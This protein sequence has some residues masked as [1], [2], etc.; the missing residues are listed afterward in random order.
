MQIINKEK[1]IIDHL[2]NILNEGQKY[3]QNGLLNR[4]SVKEDFQNLEENL[5]D[6]LLNDKEFLNRFTKK[7]NDF[8]LIQSENF[9]RILETKE[10]LSNSYTK[11][12]QDIGLFIGNRSAKQ[13]QKV[14]LN[15]PYKDTFLIAGMDKTDAEDIGGKS[16]NELI[17]EIK[18]NEP[19][20]NEVVSADE[21]ESLKEPKA[22]HNVVK[23]SITGKEN[24]DCISKE[25]NLLIKG[26]NL[27]SLYSAAERYS[28][29]V[30]LIYLDVPYYFR[31]K[32]NMNTFQYNSNFPLSA[33][34]TFMKNR[35][36][37]ARKFLTPEGTIFIQS[38]D[39]S[40]GYLKV[41]LDEIFKPENFINTIA[42]K[43]KNIQG[44]SGGGEDKRLKK[45]VEFIHI[46]A[47]NSSLLKP[48]K[49]VYDYTE[50]T[51]L[52]EEYRTEEKSWKYTAI[53][54]DEGTKEYIGST[55]SGDGEEIKVYRQHNPVYKSISQV[56]K[57][58][59]LTE[60][61]AY[62][63]YFDKIH[64]T[65]IPQSSIRPR[66]MEY[67]SVQGISTL[68]KK[69]LY[70][71]EYVPRSGRNR[72][73]TYRQ[74]YKGRKFRL[75]VWFAAV[76]EIKENV[77][78]KKD[79]MGT[80]WNY[81]SET[82]NLSKE[83]NVKLE[84]GKKPERLLKNII[85]MATEPGDI[86]LDYFFGTG[87]T[88]AVAM[89][90]NRKYIGMEQLDYGLNSSIE[91]LKNVINGDTSGISKDDDVEWKGGGSFIYA[92]LMEDNQF[93][94]TKIEEAEDF[95]QV[96]EIFDSMSNK[97]N[98]RFQ[99]TLDKIT[100]ELLPEDITLIQLKE[101]FIKTL[102]TSSLY[103]NANET[104]DAELILTDT[105]RK[106]N[107]NFYSSEV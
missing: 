30:K 54:F 69:D 50:I 38:N 39:E 91:R 89:K 83:G 7:Y 88:G 3:V 12:S 25:D 32:T 45:N 92:D 65:M 8:T 28:G 49:K 95:N 22:F 99:V 46:Y 106:F 21:I 29:K 42:V 16:I 27:M 80:F 70:S 86:V 33:W 64:Q 85:E 4:T 82:T 10:Y 41:L 93:F 81:A 37:I 15:W 40:Q 24:I 71:I 6:I 17:G 43:M 47:N 19:F 100:K 68:D 13:E 87:T 94:I 72:G 20:L 51:K 62:L 75:V 56:M 11:Y 2:T 9:I 104:E 18:N 105:D 52:M 34:L 74:F 61:E 44:A 78:Y 26:N 5:M 36:E 107:E 76:A 98:F 14:F 59:N 23:Y 58:E 31:E 103:V 73:I 67:L 102:K 55:V 77:V 96:W 48:F 1:N 57:E 101:L 66:V 97:A 35:L 79:V 84:N 90:M 53:L 60:G 63:K